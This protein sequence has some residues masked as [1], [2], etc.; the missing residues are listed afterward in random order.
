MVEYTFSEMTKEYNK[1]FHEKRYRAAIV[2]GRA[3]YQ[4]TMTDK[5]KL[6][7]DMPLFHDHFSWK[8]KFFT[9]SS[10]LKIYHKNQ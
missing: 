3:M 4:N 8:E 1:W 2:N 10:Y 6:V 7:Y 5:I 9:H